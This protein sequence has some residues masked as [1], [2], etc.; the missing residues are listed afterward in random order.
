MAEKIRVTV[1]NENVHERKNEAVKKFNELVAD[2]KVS[3]GRPEKATRTM[4]RCY[5]EANKAKSEVKAK[6]ARIIDK[7][8]NPEIGTLYY[9]HGFY[10][11]EVQNGTPELDGSFKKYYLKIH[12][13]F[14]SSARV[15]NAWTFDIDP[16][17]LGTILRM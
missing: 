5:K 2:G 12:P 3:R 4:E 8:E 6:R 10:I 1:W 14:T 9:V 7:D 11:L 13:E 17:E 16:K 15:A